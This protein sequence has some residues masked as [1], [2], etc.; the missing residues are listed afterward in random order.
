MW[1]SAMRRGSLRRSVIAMNRF[2][3]EITIAGEQDLEQLIGRVREVAEQL[4]REGTRVRYEYAVVFPEDE[5]CFL[6]YTAADRAA[7]IEAGAR[8]AATAELVLEVAANPAGS[9]PPARQT[10]VTIRKTSPSPAAAPA[11]SSLPWRAIPASAESSL[12]ERLRRRRRQ[13]TA[14]SAAA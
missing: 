3:T 8:A 13:A 7:V 1:V 10:T 9:K 2:L 12:I 5:I 11:R 14:L 6:L 4:S